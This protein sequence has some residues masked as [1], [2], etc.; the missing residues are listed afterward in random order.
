MSD[1]KM[2]P[3]EGESCL[4]YSAR[5]EAE[6]VRLQADIVRMRKAL[7]ETS[8]DEKAQKL[9]VLMDDLERILDAKP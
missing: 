9:R 5:L 2:M 7:S 3:N 1:F 4:A 8:W 6:I